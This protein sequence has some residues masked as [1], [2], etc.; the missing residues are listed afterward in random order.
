M[1]EV[2]AQHP[3]PQGSAAI[4]P[5]QVLPQGQQGVLAGVQGLVPIPKQTPPQAE[6]I[7]L[8]LRHQV[9]ENAFGIGLVVQCVDLPP[10]PVADP[11]VVAAACAQGFDV[12]PNLKS[13]GTTTR[14]G[15]GRSALR[16]A[17]QDTAR[18]ARTAAESRSA[19]TAC[20]TDMVPT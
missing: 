4:Q 18:T 2:D 8:Q 11:A 20:K 5:G 3:R 9:A 14:Q 17:S 12:S 7:L 13:M 16:A 10:G 15:K 6:E 19:R 1:V